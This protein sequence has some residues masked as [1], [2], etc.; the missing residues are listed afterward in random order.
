V[1]AVIS[2]ISGTAVFASLQ[3]DQIAAWEKITVGSIAVLTAATTALQG[4]TATRVKALKD[5]RDK[6]HQLHRRIRAEIAAAAMAPF[7]SD[8]AEKIEAD[9][10]NITAGMSDVTTGAWD[11]AKREMWKDM[12]KETGLVSDGQVRI[13]VAAPPAAS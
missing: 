4:W 8:Y 10:S 2:A 7:A 13:R 12:R 3:A 11:K 1:S 5:Q 9:L 6:F